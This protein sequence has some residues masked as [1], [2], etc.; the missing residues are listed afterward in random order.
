MAKI[1]ISG[2]RYT[3]GQRVNW[4]QTATLGVAVAVAD[5][6]CLTSCLFTPLSNVSLT[7][8]HVAGVQPQNVDA[9]NCSA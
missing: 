3:D 2:V 7:T 1:R 9:V 6:P 8:Q 4:Q 5:D